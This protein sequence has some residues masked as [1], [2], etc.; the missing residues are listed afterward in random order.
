MNYRNEAIQKLREYRAKKNS[1][2]T[3]PEEVK[4]L[5]LEFDAIKCALGISGRITTGS[6]VDNRLISNIARRE[7]LMH[8]L[9]ITELFTKTVEDALAF[10]D[11]EE[12]RIISAMYID[13]VPNAVDRLR[14]SLC[15]EQAAIYNRRNQALRKFTLAFYGM[16][17]SV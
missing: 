17:E 16:T 12:L 2:K 9:R 8:T 1:L 6:D 10:L 11:D 3:I 13:P 5:E 14:E 7:E 15:L 4:R